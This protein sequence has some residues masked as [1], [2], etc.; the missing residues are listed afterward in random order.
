LDLH[1][2]LFPHVAPSGRKPQLPF[3]HMLPIA[4][5]PFVLHPVV[6]AFSVQRKGAHGMADPRMHL[7]SPSQLEAGMRFWP[8]Q[9]DGLQTV[10]AG[11]FAHPPAPLH[12][13]F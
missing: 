6:Q 7:P 4:Q 8:V 2:A 9:V 5:S 10:P 1:S 12:V 11:N 13:P 3:V